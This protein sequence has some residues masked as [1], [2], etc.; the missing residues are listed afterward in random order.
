M[1]FEI[2][3]DLQAGNLLPAVIT[4]YA[5]AR[6]RDP[7]ELD[8]DWIRGNP[9]PDGA[10]AGM[11]VN[12]P[13]RGDDDAA[14]EFLA[15]VLKRTGAGFHAMHMTVRYRRG[16]IS[17]FAWSNLRPALLFHH[18]WEPEGSVSTQIW[19]E[20]AVFVPRSVRFELTPGAMRQT[21]QKAG[22]ISGLLPGDSERL[23]RVLLDFT[24]GMYPPSYPR[25][26]ELEGDVARRIVACLPAK[27]AEVLLR[28]FHE[29]ESLHDFRGWLW[30]QYWAVA[31]RAEIQKTS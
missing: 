25:P 20:R 5:S 6:A 12:Y 8:L 19:P 21:E 3:S 1:P 22:E 2:P 11:R 16:D 10:D 4:S 28:N 15:I 23:A 7:D 18:T 31:N 9:L 29:V 30:Q 14:M 26:D 27:A 24:N 13:L 17:P